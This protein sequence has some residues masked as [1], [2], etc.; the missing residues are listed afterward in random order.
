MRKQVGIFIITTVLIAFSSCDSR[1]KD[2]KDIALRMTRIEDLIDK[3]ALNAAKIELDSIH[4]L[5]PRMVDARRVA[6]T[7]ED[8]I[9]RRESLRTLAYCDSILPFK[10]HQA[11][12]IQKNFRFEKNENYQT[13]GNYVYKTL[14]IEANID[15]IYL[16]A[17]V[18][19]NADFYLI[20][21]FT[22]NHK[23]NHTNV[24]ASVG[25]TYAHTDEVSLSSP[26]NH[27]FSEDGVNWEVVTFKNEVAGNVPV[28]IAQYATERIKITLQG[29][30]NY[31][32]YL[33]DAD[34]KALSE[35]YNFWVAKK[36]V[37]MLQKEIAKA[38]AII[39]QINQRY[40]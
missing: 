26:M 10:Q 15:R 4:L 33:S 32:Y 23:L 9:V 5:Y 22:G 25:E 28:F 35:T 39:E 2:E 29:E 24:K 7:L 31:A 17:Y 37:V 12:S 16:R 6:K 19:E 11:D 14:Q 20:S 30:R 21:N 40:Y 36:D 38:K 18:D 1:R 34:K 8:T 3:N 13:I 27:D